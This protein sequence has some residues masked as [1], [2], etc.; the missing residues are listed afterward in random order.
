MKQVALAS[1]LN[2]GGV[3]GCHAVANAEGI[4][5]EFVNGDEPGADFGARAFGAGQGHSFGLGGRVE[6]AVI[7]HFLTR[8]GREM[9]LPSTPRI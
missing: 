9:K 8:G 1:A 2:S 4:A 5:C 3:F 6:G 7:A